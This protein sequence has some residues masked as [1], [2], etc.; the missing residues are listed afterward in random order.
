MSNFSLEVHENR[1]VETLQLI[2]SGY[3]E[4]Q[5]VTYL[6][7]DKAL[8]R[9]KMQWRTSLHILRVLQQE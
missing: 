1:N 7:N 5:V 8:V 4:K 6:Y 3:L 2:N 9:H